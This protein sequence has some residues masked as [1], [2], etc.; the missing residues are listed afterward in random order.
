MGTQGRVC[1]GKNES[2]AEVGSQYLAGRFSCFK[3]G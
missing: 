1:M 2:N 3:S